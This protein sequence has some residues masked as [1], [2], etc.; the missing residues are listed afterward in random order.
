MVYDS[1]SGEAAFD[2]SYTG[3]VN[4]SEASGPANAIQFNGGASDFSGVSNLTF[5]ST[6]NILGVIGDISLNGNIL[7]SSGIRI[8]DAK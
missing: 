2:A 3:I 1:S 4:P 5:N 7:M 6:T 8:G